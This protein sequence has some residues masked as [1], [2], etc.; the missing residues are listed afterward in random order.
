MYRRP[1]NNMGAGGALA[2]LMFSVL[3]LTVFTLISYN[4]AR[5]EQAAADRMV[6][7]AVAYYEADTQ[8]E[9]II[10]GILETDAQAQAAFTCPVD[11][12]RELYVALSGGTIL[13]WRLRDT[14]EWEAARHLPVWTGE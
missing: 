4:T 5:A 13:E 10:A 11:E 3:S 14:D 6:A 12:Y 7:M 9:Q 8:A 2:V 1:K